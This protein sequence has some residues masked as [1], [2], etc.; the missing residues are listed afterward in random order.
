MQANQPRWVSRWLT[1]SL[2]NPKSEQLLLRDRRWWWWV[3][4]LLCVGLIFSI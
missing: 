4:R 2:T 3:F 1:L